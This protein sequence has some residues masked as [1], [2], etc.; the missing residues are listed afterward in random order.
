MT[1]AIVRFDQDI[2]D[3]FDAMTSRRSELSAE[4]VRANNE[5]DQIL[6]NLGE[7]VASGAKYIKQIDRLA[8]LRSESEALEAGILH[9]TNQCDL[10]RRMNT[11][12]T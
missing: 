8:V 12:L 6:S 3:R 4:L 10:L 5:Q 2:K 11:W 1:T 9:L 7:L